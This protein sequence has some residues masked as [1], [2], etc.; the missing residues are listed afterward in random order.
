MSQK[1]L[2]RYA[3]NKVKKGPADSDSEDETDYS[4]FQSKK[5]L[6]KEKERR[7]KELE[8]LTKMGEDIINDNSA[9]A[10]RLPNRVSKGMVV[11]PQTGTAK[12]AAERD[13][14]MSPSSFLRG[15]ASP[16]LTSFVANTE[17]DCI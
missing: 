9:G 7:K 4:K 1:Q 2:L 8:E 3:T 13:V 12:Q 5:D 17:E 14:M 10:I 6:E 16:R 11:D 15:A